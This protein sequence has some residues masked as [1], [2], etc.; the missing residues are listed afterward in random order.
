MERENDSQRIQNASSAVERE[1]SKGIL[2]INLG[3]GLA[4]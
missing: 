4:N 3:G 1:T 2:S